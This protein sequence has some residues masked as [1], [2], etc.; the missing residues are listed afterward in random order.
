MLSKAM[1]DAINKQ[2]NAEISSAYLYLSMFAYCAAN[3]RPGCAHW[4]RVQW[5]E[6]LTHAMR[7]FE[8][9]NDRGGRA[10]LRA[11]P[12]PATEFKSLL[13][14]FKQVLDHEKEVTALIHRLYETA[15][16]ENDY[17]AQVMLQWFINEQVEEEKSAAEVVEQLKL[18]GDQ[19]APVLMLDRHLAMRKSGS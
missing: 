17:P 12:Q 8:H 13:D 2:I 4:M 5:E 1:Q 11:I 15:V 6:E 7:L 10:V 18:I 16:K 9:V 14:V 3:N 19:G